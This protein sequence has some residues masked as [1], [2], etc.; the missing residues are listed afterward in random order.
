MATNRASPSGFRGLFDSLRRLADRLDDLGQ[1]GE[2]ERTVRFGDASSDLEGVAGIRVRTGLGGASGVDVK[3]ETAGSA[4][5]SG[6]TGADDARVQRPVAD[7]QEAGDVL[8]VH[9]DMPGIAA[10]DVRVEQQGERR[11]VVS[12]ARS[13]RRYRAEVD[14][15]RSVRGDCAEVRADRGIVQIRFPIAGSGSDDAPSP[16]SPSADASDGDVQPESDDGRDEPP[17]SSSSRPDAS[18]GRGA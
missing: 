17:S 8:L 1:E 12:A 3:V 7:V 2:F 10:A 18:G 6:S 5:A 16:S 14:L 4:Q 15:P 13:G 11:Y 9:V